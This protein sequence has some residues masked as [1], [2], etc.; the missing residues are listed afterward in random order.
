[1]CS[2]NY[3]FNLNYFRPLPDIHAEFAEK[4]GCPVDSK[5]IHKTM[6]CLQNKPAHE[7]QEGLNM[8]DQCNSKLKNNSHNIL[9]KHK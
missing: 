9:L 8:F 4:M 5:D 1:M 6:T 7:F 3:Q 2:L